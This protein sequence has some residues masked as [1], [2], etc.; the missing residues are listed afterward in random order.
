MGL[1]ES[2]IVDCLEYF[3]VRICS[4]LGVPDEM[5][6]RESV[7]MDKEEKNGSYKSLDDVRLGD[8]VNGG[9]TVVLKGVW[10]G[11]PYIELDKIGGGFT[12]SRYFYDFSNVSCLRLVSRVKG[13]RCPNISLLGTYATSDFKKVCTVRWFGHFYCVEQVKGE[14]EKAY[15]G[16]SWGG[17]CGVLEGHWKRVEEGVDQWE[18]GKQV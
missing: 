5:L 1:D 10:N 9:M 11:L 16:S 13:R 18:E 7:L 8:V 3:N 2:Q 14:V 12:G 15:H 4:A 6:R 17:F